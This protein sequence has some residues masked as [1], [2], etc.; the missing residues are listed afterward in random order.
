MWWRMALVII[1]GVITCAFIVGILKVMWEKGEYW[2]VGLM[3]ILTVLIVGG[4]NKWAWVELKKQSR[5]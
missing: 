2:Q 4:V 1:M 5:E 3:G